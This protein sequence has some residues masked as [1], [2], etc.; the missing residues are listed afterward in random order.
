VTDS[1]PIFGRETELQAVEEFLDGIGSGTSALRREGEAVLRARRRLGWGRL[2][3][4]SP[5]APGAQASD[6]LDGFEPTPESRGVRE[7]DARATPSP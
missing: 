1:S 5:D 3:R 2:F 7:S 4:E 6:A